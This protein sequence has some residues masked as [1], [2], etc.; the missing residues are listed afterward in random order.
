MGV[1]TPHGIGRQESFLAIQE[2]TPFTFEEPLSADAV[3]VIKSEMDYKQNRDERI[4]KRATLGLREHITA[5]KEVSWS[6]RK[7]LIPSGTAGTPPDD[8]I[9]LLN[10]FGTYVNTPATSDIYT[11]SSSQSLRGTMSL[12]RHVNQVLQQNIIGAYV[13][14]LSLEFSG[15]AH[16]MLTYEGGGGTYLETGHSLLDGALSGAEATITVDNAELFKVN[17]LI[18]IGT[19]DNSGAG[20]LV[21]SVNES[22]EVLGITPNNA[23]AQSDNTDVFP[24]VPAETTAGSPLSGTLGSLDLDANTTIPWTSLSVELA[25]NTVAH[26][27]HG[28]EDSTTDVTFGE[29][30]VT[31]NLAL[32]L[33]RDHVEHFNKIGNFV[34]RDLEFVSGTVAGQIATLSL[35]AIEV[36]WGPVDFPEGAEVVNV[37]LP[38]VALETGSGDNEMI[39]AFT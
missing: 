30:R 23:G 5:R 1:N 2:T 34:A 28:H 11:V 21:T 25:L 7:Y 12:V 6:I 20:Y 39:L 10:A 3:K 9:F 16:P 33:R 26:N 15:T 24:F 35:N 17:S 29:R 4:D 27:D 14:K 31:G 8:H 13:D 37:T 19:D 18:Q 22:T 32:K 36:M 38:W